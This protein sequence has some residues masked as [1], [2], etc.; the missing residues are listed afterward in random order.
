MEPI[1]G[2]SQAALICTIYNRILFKSNRTQLQQ[3]WCERLKKEI[4]NYLHDKDL[5]SVFEW[6]GRTL[7]LSTCGSKSRRKKKQ[8]QEAWKS[9]C[10]YP[11]LYQAQ[12]Q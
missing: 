6:T 2:L 9:L 1:L 8:E 7:D 3:N 10:S 5:K 4:R 11:V 12:Y